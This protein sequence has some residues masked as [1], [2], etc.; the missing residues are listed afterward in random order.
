MEGE[1]EVGMVV[2][3]TEVIEVEAMGETEVVVVMGAGDE[4][5][6]YYVLQV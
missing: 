3:A 4:L 5:F 6:L 1:V 2:A